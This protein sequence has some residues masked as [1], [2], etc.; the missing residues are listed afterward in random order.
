MGNRHL[1]LLAVAL[2]MLW[3]ILVVCPDS[4]KGEIVR[5][6]DC[7]PDTPHKSYFP[8][9]K[10]RKNFHYCSR[11]CPCYDACES[12]RKKF[13]GSPRSPTAKPPPQSAYDLK[14][15]SIHVKIIKPASSSKP[16][17]TEVGPQRKVY[18]GAVVD[19]DDTEVGTQR[20]V[21]VC[22]VVKDGDT[23]VGTHLWQLNMD[24]ASYQ[25][26]DYGLST[27]E[28]G[29]RKLMCGTEELL[30][31]VRSPA[32]SSTPH[33][34]EV[35]RPPKSQFRQVEADVAPPRLGASTLSVNAPVFIPR[36]P[37]VPEPCPVTG[38]AAPTPVA[39]NCAV[40][41]PG[42][43]LTLSHAAVASSK[44]PSSYACAFRHGNVFYAWNLRSENKFLFLR[45]VKRTKMH[46]YKRVYV[47]PSSTTLKVLSDKRVKDFPAVPVSYFNAALQLYFVHAKVA[48]EFADLDFT[49]NP[50]TISEYALLND[51]P[52]SE[53][54]GFSLHGIPMP[55]WHDLNVA[56][57]DIHSNA[58]RVWNIDES[59]MGIIARNPISKCLRWFKIENNA[60][61]KPCKFYGKELPFRYF[62][63]K[64]KK[65]F[66]SDCP[67]FG[68]E[69]KF[70]EFSDRDENK[71][72]SIMPALENNQ[73][74]VFA[75]PI[76]G[77][78]DY[79]ELSQDEQERDVSS[80]SNVALPL[81]PECVAVGQASVTGNPKP[82]FV[83][84]KEVGRGSRGR[85]KPPKAYGR[86]SG[87]RPRRLSS[88]LSILRRLPQGAKQLRFVDRSGETLLCYDVES[89]VDRKDTAATARPDR[90]ALAT[91]GPSMNLGVD[92]AAV[93]CR[94]PKFEFVNQRPCAAQSA[95]TATCTKVLA[96]SLSLAAV[97]GVLG[98]N[99]RS[100]GPTQPLLTR[101]SE[102]AAGVKR[103]K[104]LPETPEADGNALTTPTPKFECRTSLK[105]D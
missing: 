41:A 43:S 97:L 92:K 72:S 21:F 39:S 23:E 34:P 5:Q 57:A 85:R 81:P 89:S 73:D 75:K 53:C 38:E 6:K 100:S 58:L 94:P 91:A 15:D 70:V 28:E 103:F 1:P 99:M 24:G 71:F 13:G 98:Y 29:L 17:S 104:P 18:V 14:R 74:I 45:A 35:G 90:D 60:L 84:R 68:P 61:E 96:A 65:R 62:C 54:C 36:G 95:S 76:E 20:K 31:E 3:G 26:E 63:P 12:A 33:N 78:A 27:D 93:A 59:T 64:I 16:P 40:A 30:T 42:N 7:N 105:R 56:Y 37:A 80:A 67:I 50:E 46:M 47:W 69:P 102:T 66:R 9:N 77:K 10:E 44:D 4:P 87:P 88:L 86:G 101:A 52:D 11:G 49:H 55:R 22:E 79:T 51:A 2:A 32:P 48:D 82:P 19:K 83:T 25:L 8:L